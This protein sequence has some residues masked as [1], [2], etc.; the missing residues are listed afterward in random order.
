[1]QDDDV[2]DQIKKG[3]AEAKGG[4]FFYS[5]DVAAEY[6]DALLND[7]YTWI[8]VGPNKLRFVKAKGWSQ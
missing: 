5:G 4:S 8:K 2:I 6:L 7:G 1:M 3:V